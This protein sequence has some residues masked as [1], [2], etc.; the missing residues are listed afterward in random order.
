MIGKLIN[1]PELKDGAPFPPS[2]FVERETALLRQQRAALVESQPSLFSV[3]G[4]SK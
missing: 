3:A 2:D 4:S 1:V